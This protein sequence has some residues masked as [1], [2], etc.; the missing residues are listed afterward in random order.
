MKETRSVVRRITEQQSS[1]TPPQLILNRHCSECEFQ[2]RCRQLSIEKDDL[3]LLSGISE[4]ERKKQHNKGIFSVTQLS[5]TFRPR[6]RSKSSSSKPE[7][8]YP[9]LK[10]L[11]I[12]E[13]KIHIAGK[14]E[15]NIS[16]TPIYFDV[17]GVPDRDFYYLIGLRFKSGE[18]LI[19]RS[20]W[21]NEMIDER[22]IWISFIET[23][24]NIDTPQLIHYGAYESTFLK[25][26]KNRYAGVVDSSSF[27]DQLIATSTNLLSIFY[28]QIYFPTYSNGLKEIARHLG[29]DWTDKDASGF[30]ALLLRTKWEYTRDPDIQQKLG[31][32]NAEDCEA[33]EKVS[34]VVSRL[35]SRQ[36]ESVIPKDNSIVHIDSMKRES[37]YRFQ[38]NDFKL[39]ELEYINQSAYWNYQRDKIYVRSSKRLKRVSEI[40][41]KS[42]DRDL[43]INKVIECKWPVPARCPKCNNRK[44]YKWARRSKIVQDLKI[45]PTSIKRWTVKYLYHLYICRQCGSQFNPPQRHWTRSKYGANLRSY[46]IYQIIELHLPQ[47]L[48][49]Q[50]INQLYGFNLGH[51]VIVN[52]KMYASRLYN[53]TYEAILNKIMNGKLIHVD[54]TKISLKGKGAFVWVFT[55]LEEVAYIHTETREGDV[56]QSLLKDFKGVLVSDF[57]AAYDSINCPQ[58]KCLIHL[59]RDLNDEIL[60]HPFNEELKELVRDFAELA[61]PMIETIDRF[62]LKT[63][64]LRKHKIYVERFYKRLAAHKYQSDI[65][66]KY[67][68]R[69]DRNRDKLFTF[70][71]YDGVPWNNNN[72]EHAIKAFATLRKVIGGTS[73]NRGM[74][75][76]LTLLSICETCKY[77]GISFLDFLRSGEKDIDEF[78]QNKSKTISVW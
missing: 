13:G 58:Q 52:Q 23:L 2:S 5:Y 69:F 33:L 1:T 64:F 43:P 39:P 14:P 48:V 12:R 46:I 77:K 60:K 11:A 32:Y 8:Y 76:Y 44:V 16:G 54:E 59:I 74:R 56:A 50:S 22:E 25:R 41:A 42:S 65:A 73:S 40:A 70:L 68:K 47:R 6:R 27:V 75:D 63:H 66:L 21:A 9:A 3:S 67:K 53:H 35:C 19:Q 78:I 45:G 17:E 20:F 34:A 61:K 18:S 72:A 10:A 28:A 26:M 31:T 4:K 55:N 62:G 30:N 71:D 37:P 15:L 57:Y 7:K 51:D 38:K 29:Y 49:G 24:T 36:D